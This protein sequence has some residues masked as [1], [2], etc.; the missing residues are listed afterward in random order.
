MSELLSRRALL[1]GGSALAFMAACGKKDDGIKVGGRTTTTQGQRNILNT[2]I[3]STM[4]LAGIEERVSFGLLQGVP[5]SPVAKDSV[6]HVAFQKPGTKVLTDPV[7]AEYKSGGLELG[8]YVVRYTFDVPGNW[9]VRAT[10]PGKHP[11]DAAIAIADPNTVEFPVPG[12]ALPKVVTPTTADAMGVEPICTRAEGTCPFHTASLDSLVG[13][14][15]PTVVLLATPAL[16]VSAM[17]GP[18]LDILISESAA[19]RDQLNI[20]HVEVFAD[21]TGKTL[22]PAF[23]AFHTDSEP[24]MYLADKNGIVTERFNGPFDKSEAA[25]AIQR[26][27]A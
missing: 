18:V 13:N 6:V 19:V 12:K 2:Q 23:A 8:I 17:C 15:K 11:G 25:A 5:P 22:A 9:G 20:V 1:V 21:N 10:V 26:L 14:G 24:V 16:C 27:L 3:A 4:L 7:A